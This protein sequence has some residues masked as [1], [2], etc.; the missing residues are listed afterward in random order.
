MDVRVLVVDDDPMVR[1]L[2]T[3]VLTAQGIAVVGEATDGDEV[4]AAVAAHSPDVVLMDLHMRR[5][6]GLDAIR[7]LHRSPA[8]PAVIALTSF[9][10]DETVV[11]AL[12]A[13]AQGFLSKDDDPA[14]IAQH[15]REVADGAGALDPG[16]AAAV[17]RHMAGSRQVDARVADAL[18]QLEQ[19]TAREVEIASHLPLGLSNRAIGERLYLSESTVKAHLGRAM[20]K[21]GL[22]SREQLAVLVDRAGATAPTVGP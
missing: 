5:T 20:A 11:D 9:G 16:A 14:H 21:L 4:V 3:T 18:R 17:I 7:E 8:A 13:G 12:A 6:D 22:D 1:R 19:L 2:L 15:V 10:T